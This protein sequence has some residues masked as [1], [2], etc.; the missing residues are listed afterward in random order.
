M[1]FIETLSQLKGECKR[2]ESEVYPNVIYFRKLNERYS[3]MSNFYRS[4]VVIDGKSYLH[5]E[6]YYQSQKFVGVDDNIAE[7]IRNI[8]NPMEC[9]REAHSHHLTPQ[10]LDKWDNIRKVPVMKRGV[11]C[12]FISD[13]RLSNELLSTG[14]SILVE[15]AP[16]DSY[17]GNG[18]YKNGSNVLGKILM[19]TRDT[20][21]HINF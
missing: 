20:L 11:L 13:I 12:K 7:K 1:N 6:G 19:E 3:Y 5:I 4:R 16:W 17:W 18:K 2:L 10:Q 21:K 9:K 8:P 14:T 15:D